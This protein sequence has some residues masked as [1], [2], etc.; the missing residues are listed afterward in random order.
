MISCLELSLHDLS[1]DILQ[2]ILHLVTDLVFLKQES[3][4]H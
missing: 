2:I 1:A 3:F 4:S